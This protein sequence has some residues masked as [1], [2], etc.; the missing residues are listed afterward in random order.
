MNL[1]EAIV[2]A[3]QAHEGQLYGKVPYIFHPLRVMMACMTEEERI[4]AVLHDAVED[5]ALTLNDLFWHEAS[6]EV[7]D[8]VKC[9]TRVQE[10]ETYGEYI[11]RIKE[12]DLARIVKL[13]DLKDN[14]RH[15]P[16]FMLRKRYI[17]ALIVLGE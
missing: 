12:N 5:T 14:L 17:K 1:A 15:G 6:R 2:L 4:V 3:T 9:L 13:A 10:K 16:T 7:L 11:L 8:A